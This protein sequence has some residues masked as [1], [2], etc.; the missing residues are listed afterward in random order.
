[1]VLYGDRNYYGFETG[2]SSFQALLPSSAKCITELK[3]VPREM[4]RTNNFRGDVQPPHPVGQ[5]TPTTEVKAKSLELESS[6]SHLL[7]T[8]HEQVT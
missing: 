8:G 3:S 4:F 7:V 1:M 2:T 6:L 5:K